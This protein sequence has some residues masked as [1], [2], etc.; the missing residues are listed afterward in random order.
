MNK[1]FKVF[2][3]VSIF[4]ALSVSSVSAQ[5][6]LAAKKDDPFKNLQYRL[7]GP[8]RG[9][10]VGAVEGVASQP[11]VFY[12]GATGGGVWKT[13]DAGATWT[14]VSDGYF[15]TGSV[16]AI[17]AADSDPNTIYVGMG[18]ETVRGN[19]SAGDGV[20]KSVDGGKSWKS[21]G[22]SETQQIPRVR[23]HP[24]D[25][26]I[27]YV[28]ALGHLW[29]KNDERGIFRTKDGGKTWQKI[30]FRNSETGASDLILDPSN[31]NTIYAAFWQIS[32]KP[33]RMDSGGDGSGLF[34]SADGGDTWTE[35]TRN[36]GLPAGVDGKINVTVS[37]AN[38][39]RVWAM[40]ENKDGGLFR[41][42][43]GGDTWQKMSDSPN[44]RQRPWYFNRIYADT[45]N[46]N[47]IYVM[48]VQMQRSIDGGRTFTTVQ[49]PHSD[50]H[51]LWINPLDAKKM[52]NGNDG[53]ANVS[54][55][56][57]QTWT[58]QLQ[59]TAQFYRVTTDNDF[60]YNIYAAQQDNSTV[61]IASRSDGFAITTNDW[62]D[63]GGGESGWVTP[64]PDNSDI[65]FAGNYDGLLT[66][67]NH[68]TG[69]QRNVDVYP[70]NPMGSGA[71]EAKNRFQWNFPIL[72][73]PFKTNGKA[74]LY[75]AAEHLFRSLDE[76]VTWETMSPDL[77]RNDKSRQ[78]SSGGPISQ[79]NTS[80]EYYDTIFAV[81]ESPVKQGV[82]WTGSDDGLVQVTQ[83]NGKTWANV[84][85]KEMPE[86][87]QINQVRAS[88]FDP[89]TAYVAAVN[90]K[91]DDQRP[92]LYR[93]TDLGRSW[94]KIVSGIPVDQFTRTIVEDPNKRGFLYAGTER[95]L[96]YSSNGGDTWESLQLNLPVVPIADLTVQKREGD[97]IVAT[98]GRAF[99]VLDDLSVVYRLAEARKSEAMLFK[100]E[101][102]YRTAG[103]GGQLSPNATVGR[104][105][106]NGA[107]IN[108][109][110]KEKPVK[111]V[112]L[113]FLDASGKVI[114]KFTRRPD[115]PVAA[116]PEGR[117]GGGDPPLPAEPGLNTFVW[118]FRLPSATT[119]PGLI[120]WGGSLAGP[121]VVPGTY[122][123]RLSL[124]GKPIGTETFAVNADPR[125]STTADEFSKQ[126]ALMMD[127]NRKLS[128]THAAILEISDIRT[129]LDNVSKR[130]KG[131]ENKDLADKASN[132]SKQMTAIEEA[133]FQTKI[134]SG[135]D[136]LNYPI[137]LNNKLAALG[138]FVDGSD[139]GPTASAYLVYKDLTAQIDVELAAFAKLKDGDLADFNK[140]Y[141]ARGLPVVSS[142]K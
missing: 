53:G 35:I 63:V 77:T 28:A 123:V 119:I 120:L 87:I 51:D 32:R 40:I 91:N 74:V 106:P 46:E 81:D 125:L 9:G 27:V 102:T 3:L 45:E 94:K 54:F 76:G 37:Q 21:A 110:F 23:V 111:D 5:T 55:N 50:H 20:Y 26:N 89:A 138:A 48:N 33:F 139:D 16:G 128:E 117:R 114:R 78:R 98:H 140:Q 126:Y 83:D 72:F 73:S 62:F 8:F 69:Q 112:T 4:A 118:N 61:R 133:L 67:Y 49:A 95:G 105:P 52:I 12:F 75:T 44:I 93:T 65:V 96:F 30:L 88:P 82:I 116:V 19:V 70:D 41:S 124:D 122:Q 22:L 38:P 39:N 132:I 103:G 42:D 17:D 43:D 58:Q 115:G 66:R 10:R 14:N 108:Y 107:V 86:W 11:N 13:T 15:K 2:T 99:Y 31:P 64:H 24:R 79:D 59:P 104:N 92:Y 34:K 29:G 137:R 80:I 60:P 129:Q 97:L 6:V 113:E 68:K 7:I 141:I 127:I 84:T 135:Q 131:P 100:P 85:P 57:A 1:I 36:K 101:N 90:Y 121:R 18:E 136:A 56:A 109:Y 130:L 71:D 134:K 47:T 25:P 142:G